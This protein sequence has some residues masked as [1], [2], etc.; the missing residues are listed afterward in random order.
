MAVIPVTSNVILCGD[1]ILPNI[2][3]DN[4][5]CT[6][7]SSDGNR[8]CEIV[9]DHSLQQLVKEPT[10]G[11]NILDL[12]LTNV[13]ERVNKVTVVDG[14]PGGDH[15]AVNFTVDVSVPKISKSKRRVYNFKKANFDMFRSILG[16][17][18]WSSHIIGVSVDEDWLK[19]KSLL[20]DAD[21]C[22]P[23]VTFVGK[24]IKIGFL[25]CT[26]YNTEKE[27]TFQVIQE[28]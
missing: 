18:T 22:I 1:F 14:L 11:G 17:V 6:T 27:E 3:W 25:R 8:L 28:I 13:E 2:N 4:I 23:K 10:R 15:D 16:M 24:R 7:P 5:S 26:Y 20:F 12:L 9:L 21:H 19:F